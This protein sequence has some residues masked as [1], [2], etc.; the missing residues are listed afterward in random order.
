M[1]DAPA[2]TD[3]FAEVRQ[4]LSVDSQALSKSHADVRLEHLDITCDGCEVEPIVGDRFKCTVCEDI[5]L[6]RK[7]MYALTAARL[8]MSKEGAVPEEPPIP[9]EDVKRPKSWVSLLR[10][11]KW[12]A[13]RLAVPCLHHSHKFLRCLG[14]ERAVVLST[15]PAGPSAT[16]DSFLG[17]FPPSKTLCGDCAWIVVEAASTSDG[18]EGDGAAAAAGGSQKKT[19]EVGGKTLGGRQ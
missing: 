14:P 9:T 11:D 4:S 7:C 16:L 5:D 19:L 8:N 10:A 1:S 18:K 13:L 3:I 12:A 2:E 15:E 17:S 6:C